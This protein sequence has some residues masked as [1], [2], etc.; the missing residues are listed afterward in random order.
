MV[1]GWGYTKVGVLVVEGIKI[2]PWGVVLL[3]EKPRNCE[4]F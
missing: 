4:V 2:M 1:V 3:N